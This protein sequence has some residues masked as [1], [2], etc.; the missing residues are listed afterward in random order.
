M[1]IYTMYLL[2]TNKSA[3]KRV[4]RK[5]GFFE[6]KKAYKSHLCAHKNSRRLRALSVRSKISIQD[7]WSFS[8]M[9]P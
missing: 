3:L 2:K 4:K 1:F 7:F 9:L 6:R 8:K 5:K